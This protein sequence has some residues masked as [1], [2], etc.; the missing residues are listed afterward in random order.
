VNERTAFYDVQAELGKLDR[1]KG[2][3]AERL[4]DLEL[5]RL[6]SL[7]EALMPTA[8]DGDVPAVLALVWVMERRAKLMGLD[9]ST[10]FEGQIR[11][12][13]PVDISMDASP[14]PEALPP[15]APPSESQRSR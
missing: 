14:D 9:A 5:E 15:L 6:D 4:R 7:T 2:R 13:Q 3:L 8:Q 12:V 10:K 1:T 11:H